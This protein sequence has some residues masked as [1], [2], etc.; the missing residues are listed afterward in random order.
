[1]ATVP[2][3]RTSLPTILLEKEER[4]EQMSKARS[5]HMKDV[6]GT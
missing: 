1:M 2:Q 6:E 4:G 5:S 3:G